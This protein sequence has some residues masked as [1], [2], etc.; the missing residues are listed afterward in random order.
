MTVVDITP[1]SPRGNDGKTRLNSSVRTA[2]TKCSSTEYS[3]S[4]GSHAYNYLTG[5]L[6][7]TEGDESTAIEDVVSELTTQLPQ[8]TYE[9]KVPPLNT[10]QSDDDDDDDDD[11]GEVDHVGLSLGGARSICSNSSNS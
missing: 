6:F 9:K 3:S 8:D 7:D 4:L 2:S 5:S 11:S 1:P 10:K